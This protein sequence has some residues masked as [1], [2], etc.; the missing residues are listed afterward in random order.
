MDQQYILTNPTRRLY[1]GRRGVNSFYQTADLQE[2]VRLTGP[3]AENVLLNSVPRKEREEW[4]VVALSPATG[5]NETGVSPLDYDWEKTARELNAFYADLASYC[6]K[7][8]AALARTDQKISDIAH[9]LE[10]K[11]PGIADGYRTSMMLHSLRLRRRTIKD[12]IQ[13]AGWFLTTTADAIIGGELEHKLDTMKRRKY[14][15]R[16]RTELFESSESYRSDPA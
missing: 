16:V 10:F 12:N 13:C 7:Q 1:Y 14:T 8:R 4:S 9:Y 6:V 3:K 2:A 15:P 5:S 11:R